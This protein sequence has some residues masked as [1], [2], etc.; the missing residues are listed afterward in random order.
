M[1]SMLERFRPGSQEQLGM[2]TPFLITMERPGAFG[3]EK[4]RLDN[5]GKARELGPV[6]LCICDQQAGS[7]SVR[8][9]EFMANQH[10][11][12]VARNLS[13]RLRHGRDAPLRQQADAHIGIGA[14]ERP[15]PTPR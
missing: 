13:M 6:T 1:V 12:N 14:L 10:K 4:A 2:R 11:T 5:I 7:Y 8:F 9:P 15:P 3:K